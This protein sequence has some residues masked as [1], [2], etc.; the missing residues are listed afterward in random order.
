[1]FNFRRYC[2]IASHS[3][4]SCL[5]CHQQ[6]VSSTYTPSL[7]AHAVTSV[8]TQGDLV[9]VCLRRGNFCSVLFPEFG[10]KHRDMYP[11][12]NSRYR[13]F[14]HPTDCLVLPLCIPPLSC[15]QTL[16]AT[17]LIFIPPVLPLP[18][19]QLNAVTWYV[20]L[21]L[22]SLSQMPSRFIHVVVRISLLFV[23]GS[24]LYGCAAF[25]LVTSWGTFGLFLVF[26]YYE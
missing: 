16:A 3:G 18:D 1:M 15:S 8:G 4:G 12:P 24:P 6:C 11:S 10:L 2:Q 19:C 9:L 17:G 7:V 23:G 21:H 20:V 14:H 5:H 13:G 25:Y 26:V 22:A